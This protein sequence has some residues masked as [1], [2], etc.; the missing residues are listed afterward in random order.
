MERLS[1]RMDKLVD[2][3]DYAAVNKLYQSVMPFLP[4]HNKETEGSKF[5]EVLAKKADSD[6]RSGVFDQFCRSLTKISQYKWE[7]TMKTWDLP[8]KPDGW[9]NELKVQ[10]AIAHTI[11]LHQDWVKKIFANNNYLFDRDANKVN[12]LDWRGKFDPTVTTTQQVIQQLS[13]IK[14]K[15]PYLTFEDVTLFCFDRVRETSFNKRPGNADKDKVN[16]DNT[17]LLFSDRDL[18]LLISSLNRDN[19]LRLLDTNLEK[20]FLDL[21]HF[22]SSHGLKC[23]DECYDNMSVKGKIED[24]SQ[25]AADLWMAWKSLKKLVLNRRLKRRS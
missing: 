2:E 25:A 19:Y 11:F 1:E 9:V 18:K 8:V 5:W 20:E 13:D 10:A 15:L 12:D 17:P 3:K 7:A 24:S 23:D 4:M 14:K 22:F 16:Y 6:Y 21:T